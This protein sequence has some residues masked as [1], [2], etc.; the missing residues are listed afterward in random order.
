MKILI[1]GQEVMEI[2][3]N[4]VRTLVVPNGA[5][6]IAGTYG[7]ARNNL[8]TKTPVS[9]QADSTPISFNVVHRPDPIAGGGDVLFEVKN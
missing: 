3:N 7:N 8:R 4:S 5:H 1:D 2:A 9:F 6:T